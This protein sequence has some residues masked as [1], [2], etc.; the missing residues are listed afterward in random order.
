MSRFFPSAAP[1]N[2][3]RESWNNTENVCR[4]K[5]V[6]WKQLIWGETSLGQVSLP[7]SHSSFS[8][9]KEF[10]INQNIW[11][12]TVERWGDVYLTAHQLQHSVFPSY[13]HIVTQ[14]KTALI[15]I[16]NLQ[17]WWNML[18]KWNTWRALCRL[19][20]GHAG[21]GKLCST[22]SPRLGLILPYFGFGFRQW[23]CQGLA[24]P[25]LMETPT[26]FLFRLTLGRPFWQ[27]HC[28]I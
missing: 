7:K 8:F 4:H 28:T 26:Y 11:E 10:S 25:P 27:P 5:T 23:C 12:R 24:L 20:R 13:I 21:P 16:F 17:M 15:L 2:R 6:W 3:P 9:S 14:P 19:P 1:Q 22:R 18:M